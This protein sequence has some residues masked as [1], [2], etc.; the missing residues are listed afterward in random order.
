MYLGSANLSRPSYIAHILRRNFVF[1]V[2]RYYDGH[3]S[4]HVGG[5]WQL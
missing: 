3:F 1:S 4:Q 5:S 2:L